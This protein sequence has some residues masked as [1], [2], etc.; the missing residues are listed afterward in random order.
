MEARAYHYRRLRAVT[1]ESVDIRRAVNRPV[2]LSR[3]LDWC[4][5]NCDRGH[6]ALGWPVPIADAQDTGQAL[7]LSAASHVS[8]HGGI[9][10]YSQLESRSYFPYTLSPMSTLH[11]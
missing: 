7:S 2:T 3:Q 4:S 10:P 6:G 8:H 1:G 9:K 11:V 5:A